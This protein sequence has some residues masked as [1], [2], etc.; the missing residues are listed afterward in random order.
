[1]CITYKS[2]FELPTEAE[3]T[4]CICTTMSMSLE[5]QLRIVGCAC[6]L[7][8]INKGNSSAASQL[9]KDKFRFYFDDRKS[10]MHHSSVFSFPELIAAL[11]EMRRPA[12]RDKAVF[13]P[14]M[15]LV[16]YVL[17]EEVYYRLQISSRNLTSEEET[18]E[19]GAQ[20]VSVPCKDNTS[21]HNIHDLLIYLD[22]KKEFIT[23]S[24]IDELKERNFMIPGSVN[25]NIKITVS[26]INGGQQ[27]DSELVELLDN[28]SNT[29]DKCLYI[30]SPDYETAQEKIDMHRVYAPKE[31][32]T[33]AKLYYLPEKD[34]GT[35]WLGSG[36]LSDAAMKG[37]N[38][39]CMVKITNSGNYFSVDESNDTFC[40]FGNECVRV[41]KA[42]EYTGN[43]RYGVI[44]KLASFIEKTVF[45]GKDYFNRVRISKVSIATTYKRTSESIQYLPLGYRDD[46]WRD[47]GTLYVHPFK[48]GKEDS[49]NGMLRVKLTENGETAETVVVFDQNTFVNSINDTCSYSDFIN[50]PWLALLM[51]ATNSEEAEANRKL[52]IE[53][54]K[55][56]QCTDREKGYLKELSAMYQ[57]FFDEMNFEE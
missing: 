7:S 3:L 9:C 35:V 49:P 5:E 17:K 52:F 31:G 19:T 28:E 20:L 13:H 14:K 36:N 12:P 37:S 46:K 57:T 15:I 4:H 56:I 8:V 21:N 2:L 48:A 25:S 42:K 41:I 55:K 26:G 44:A 24:M 34:G 32:K 27:Q 53:E 54:M 10:D 50:K 23:D 45:S 38:V 16:R 11:L 6:G 43:S 30:L 51:K 18:F 40:A 1:M 33:H 22:A 47:I 29:Q 39:E